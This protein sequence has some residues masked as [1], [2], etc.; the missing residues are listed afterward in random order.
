MNNI[1]SNDE[2]FRT[3]DYE[4]YS[5]VFVGSLFF[6]NLNLL[7]SIKFEKKVEDKKDIIYLINIRFILQFESFTGMKSFLTPELRLGCSD[8]LM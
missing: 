5:E 3:A 1:L 8:R 6:R 7:F 4:V 2:H